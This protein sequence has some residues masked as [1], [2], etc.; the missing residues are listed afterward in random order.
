MRKKLFLSD[1]ELNNLSRDSAIEALRKEK[2]YVWQE[3]SAV[4]VTK[5]GGEEDE[6][7]TGKISQLLEIVKKQDEDHSELRFDILIKEANKL[8]KRG[9]HKSKS[10]SQVRQCC[11]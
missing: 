10:A 7:K 4:L 11:L 5:L 6:C 2:N 9:M 1:T 3:K 8:K